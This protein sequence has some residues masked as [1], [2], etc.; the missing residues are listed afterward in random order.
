M[1]QDN[2]ELPCDG[3][4]R[5]SSWGERGMGMGKATWREN[6]AHPR[7]VL[8][9]GDYGWADGRGKKRADKLL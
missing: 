8:R 4:G 3:N 1:M 5:I 9:R 2:G 7:S 6:K